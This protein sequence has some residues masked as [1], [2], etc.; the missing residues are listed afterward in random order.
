MAA[1]KQASQ[2]EGLMLNRRQGRSRRWRRRNDIHN[3]LGG[4]RNLR[5]ARMA[6]PSRERGWRERERERERERARLSPS[7]LSLPPRDNTDFDTF[8]VVGWLAGS[9]EGRKEGEPSERDKGPSSFLP[10]SP[11]LIQEE[12]GALTSQLVTEPKILPPAESGTTHLGRLSWLSSKRADADQKS[13]DR[14][15]AA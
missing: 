14:S 8:P 11:L 5:Q 12:R 13:V 2:K 9:K 4:L 15:E 10:A 3:G 1:K 7:P 6:R